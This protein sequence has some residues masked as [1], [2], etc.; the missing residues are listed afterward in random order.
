MKNSRSGKRNTP[1]IKLVAL[2]CTA[3]A[4]VPHHKNASVASHEKPTLGLRWFSQPEELKKRAAALP[5]TLCIRSADEK[6][7]NYEVENACAAAEIFDYDFE[8]RAYLFQWVPEE[9]PLENPGFFLIDLNSTTGQQPQGLEWKPRD[10]THVTQGFDS[11]VKLNNNFQ[12]CAA[13]FLK[14]LK[15]STRDRPPCAS[16]NSESCRSFREWV[17]DNGMLAKLG[18]AVATTTTFFSTARF[19]GNAEEC[20]S[21]SQWMRVQECHFARDKWYNRIRG[22]SEPEVLHFDFQ[23]FETISQC[24]RDVRDFQHSCFRDPGS[25]QAYEQFGRLYS[26]LEDLV[27]NT[28]AIRDDIEMFEFQN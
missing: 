12:E 20:G 18:T 22:V 26:Q 28:V 2:V 9:S 5:V 24:G 4:C 7:E 27:Q 13:L 19:K 23:I 21:I 15:D 8:K 11:C 17:I 16:E 25:Y 14:K 6:N 1:M 10:T 3:T